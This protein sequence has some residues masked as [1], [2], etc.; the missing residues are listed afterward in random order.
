MS[1][2]FDLHVHTTKGSRD[3]S[4]TPEE[5]VAE[6][7]HIGLTGL[8]V[9]EHEGWPRHEFDEFAQRHDLV[10]VR[11]LEVYTNAGHVIVLGMDEYESGVFDIN[12]LRKLVN[13]IGGYMIL[14]H[15][16][17]FLFDPAGTYTRNVLFE[18]P[19][20]LPKTASEASIHPV[21]DLVHNLEVVNGGNLEP[22]NRLAQ[23]VAGIRRFRGTGGSDAHSTQGLGR[24]VTIFNGTVRHERDLL[25]ALREGDYAAA[26]GFN[27]GRLAHYA[28]HHPNGSQGQG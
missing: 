25:E 26:E 27:I 2:V 18:D 20:R 8:L 28:T 19:K 3:S 6:A 22:E 13:Q 17:R 5:M 7:K 15:P 24:G 16:F 9:T 14:A 1:A 10:I 23:D 4:L 21:F 11:G 12:R